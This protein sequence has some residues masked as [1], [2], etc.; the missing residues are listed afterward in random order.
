MYKIFVTFNFRNGH[1]SNQKLVSR[2]RNSEYLTTARRTGRRWLKP[3][4]IG[5][6]P[7]TT[8]PTKR[9]TLMVRGTSSPSPVVVFIFYMVKSFGFYIYIIV[10]LGERWGRW[11]MPHVTYT[12]YICRYSHRKSLLVYPV[13]REIIN[14]ILQSALFIMHI[15]F[16]YAFIS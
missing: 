6:Y 1:A 2:Q 13:R 3:Q 5:R 9:R 14:D 7:W 12:T 15:G 11:S 10:V 8:A 16:Y 4:R